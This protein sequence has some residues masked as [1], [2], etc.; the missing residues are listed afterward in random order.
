MLFEKDALDGT[1]RR[2]TE[3]QLEAFRN[4]VR[5][6][7]AALDTRRKNTP[8]R[9]AA[10]HTARAANRFGFDHRFWARPL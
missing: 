3:Q 2:G 8:R 4:G 1:W 10:R 6:L 5:K 9:R 7:H